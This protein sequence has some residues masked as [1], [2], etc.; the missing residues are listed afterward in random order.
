MSETAYWNLMYANA[1]DQT[2][3]SAR[4]RPRLFID[5]DKWCALYG[6][7]INDGVAGFGDSPGAAFWDF[8]RAWWE[9]LK[10]PDDGLEK[11]AIRQGGAPT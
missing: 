10:K 7:N 8:D 11:A 9:K 2:E 3:P 5:G 4:Y 6:D 1:V